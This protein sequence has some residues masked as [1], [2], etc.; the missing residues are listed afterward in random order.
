[1]AADPGQPAVRNNGRALAEVVR[2]ILKMRRGGV[3]SRR[4]DLTWIGAEH[5]LRGLHLVLAGIQRD[6][7]GHVAVRA[8]TEQHDGREGDEPDEPA[9][10]ARGT[11]TP[12]AHALPADPHRPSFRVAQSCPPDG[13]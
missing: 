3:Q 11:P 6:E 8:E 13:N 2:R 5:L 9:P 10:S 7:R 4:I 1:M 12:D